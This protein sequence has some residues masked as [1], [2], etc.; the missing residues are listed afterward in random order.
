MS[1]FEYFIEKR[2]SRR[3]EIS[4][5]DVAWHVDH[6]LKT[7]NRIYGRLEDSNP[8]E[9]TGNFSLSRTLIYTWGDFPRGVAESPK[10]VRPP[11]NISTDSLYQQL[12]TARK[13]IQ[14]LAELPANS[15]FKHPTFKVLNR[16]QSLRF[17]EIHTHH[18]IKII[19]DI[20][21]KENPGE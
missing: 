17:L 9:Y 7:I 21:K 12:E 4:E 11:D 3:T 5:V 2:D 18:H 16:K 1:N 15:H 8:E 14:K 6:C 19:R 20:L 13:N 10:V